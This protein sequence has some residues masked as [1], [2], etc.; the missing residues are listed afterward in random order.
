[1]ARRGGIVSFINT[2][3]R[4]NNQLIKENQ[5]RA[6]KEAKENEK[7]ERE[8][9]RRVAQLEAELRKNENLILKNMN[10]EKKKQEK[11]ALALEKQGIKTQQAEEKLR[12][13]KAIQDKRKAVE[14]EK[15]KDIFYAKTSNDMFVERC[16]ARKNLRLAIIREVHK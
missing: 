7:L 3:V 12:V 6:L 5:R 14:Q 8:S 15:E 11:E 16:V 4:F 10:K 9:L 13:K 2:A 1:M